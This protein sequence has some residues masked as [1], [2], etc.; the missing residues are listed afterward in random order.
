MIIFREAR[1]PKS[2]EFIFG[3][4]INMRDSDGIFIYNS[5]RLVIMYEHTKRQPK[6]YREYRGIV[7]VVNVPYSILMP[8]A[9][10]Q[11]LADNYEQSQLIKAIGECSEQYLSDLKILLQ[12]ESIQTTFWNDF[13]Y[14]GESNDLPS[15]Q[16]DYKR[17][18]LRH[19]RPVLQCDECGKWRMLR[20]QHGL[21][22]LN[23]DE[24]WTCSLNT[25]DTKNRS[26][27]I[28]NIQNQC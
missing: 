10:K 14:F 12:L 21:E 27:K 4:N 19:V 1:R 7:T 3:L 25:D 26:F 9:N 6:N 18:R 16:I 11:E 13:G 24:P 20:Y 23:L 28:I 15:E 22:D 8:Q 2:L 5:N 17:R